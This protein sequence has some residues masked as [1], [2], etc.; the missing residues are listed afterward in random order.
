MTRS[1]GGARMHHTGQAA[2]GL[3]QGQGRQGR[4]RRRAV[5]QGGVWGGG[6]SG[7]CAPP[8][9][10]IGL[11][12]EVDAL[13][14]ITRAALLQARGWYPPPLW[15]NASVEAARDRHVPAVTALVQVCH[16]SD[17]VWWIELVV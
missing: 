4:S 7:P 17:A 13:R 11:N 5:H 8:A 12:T 6:S 1:G 3:R 16:A 14:C 9:R 15:Y 10:V 2:D